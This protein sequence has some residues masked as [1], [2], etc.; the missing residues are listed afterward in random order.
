MK[1]RNMVIS[2]RYELL[3][4]AQRGKKKKKKAKVSLML[5]LYVTRS[6]PLLSGCFMVAERGRNQAALAKHFC[7]VT[8]HS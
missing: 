6:G 3:T 4:T 1:D 8:Q 5:E 7:T 2:I